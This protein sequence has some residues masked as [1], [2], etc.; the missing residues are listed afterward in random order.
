MSTHCQV[1]RRSEVEVVKTDPRMAD[2]P[3]GLDD[4]GQPQPSPQVP[5]PMVRDATAD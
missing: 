2:S 3:S 1:Y 4:L 5:A